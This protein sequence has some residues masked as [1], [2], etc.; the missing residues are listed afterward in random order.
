LGASATAHSHIEIAEIDLLRDASISHE[1]V[2]SL[3][4]IPILGVIDESFTGFLW[5]P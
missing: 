4:I 1:K 2:L 3:P 5:S